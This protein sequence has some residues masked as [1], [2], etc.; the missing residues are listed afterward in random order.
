[1]KTKESHSKTFVPLLPIASLK[2]IRADLATTTASSTTAN[3]NSTF[4]AAA[5]DLDTTMV[6]DNNAG[7]NIL[8][9]FK[10][11]GEDSPY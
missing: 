9:A 4:S 10:R 1:L 7:R 3:E 5:G 8:Q 11:F 6:G 2:T